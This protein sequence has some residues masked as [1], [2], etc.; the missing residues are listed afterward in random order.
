MGGKTKRKVHLRPLLEPC[1]VLSP[2][3]GTFRVF[4]HPSDPWGKFIES[5]A[6]TEGVVCGW[7][8]RK[9]P[10]TKA[11]SFSSWEPSALTWD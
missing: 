3:E 7:V 2:R 8:G 4:D 6:L 1:I 10:Q 9:A 11:W 5:S